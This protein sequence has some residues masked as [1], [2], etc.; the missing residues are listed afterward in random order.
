MVIVQV[1]VSPENRPLTQSQ[2]EKLDDY[3]G[4]VPL[5]MSVDFIKYEALLPGRWITIAQCA[6]RQVR[7]PCGQKLKSKSTLSD[8]KKIFFEAIFPMLF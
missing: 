1:Y 5:G 2:G 6:F 4:G 3:Y 7:W 8:G